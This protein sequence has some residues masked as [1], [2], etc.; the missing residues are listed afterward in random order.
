DGGVVVLDVHRAW[1]MLNQDAV[2]DFQ[3]FNLAITAPT[4]ETARFHAAPLPV[5]LHV[6]GGTV[7]ALLGAFQFSSTPHKWHRLAGRIAFP[8][9]LVAALSGIWMTL[10]YPWANSDGEAVYLARLVFGAGMALSLMLGVASAVKRN[11]PAHKAWMLRAYAIGMG[12]GTQVLTHLPW[13]LLVGQPTEGPRAV[14]M[15]GAWVLNLAIA[16]WIIRKRNGAPDPRATRRPFLNA[17]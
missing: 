4:A 2:T 15:I 7:Y 9:G 17:S 3:K 8:M 13:F 6:V 12:A 16:E 14:L 1:V 10:T 11:I 5:A